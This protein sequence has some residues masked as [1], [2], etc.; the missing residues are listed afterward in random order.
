MAAK[1]C[2]SEPLFKKNKILLIYKKINSPSILNCTL[3]NDVNKNVHK[4]R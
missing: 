2:Y 1:K 3:V 4:H